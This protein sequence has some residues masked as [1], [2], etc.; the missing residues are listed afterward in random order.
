MQQGLHSSLCL[1]LRLARGYL[2]TLCSLH[3]IPYSILELTDASSES[4]ILSAAP[5]T[6][7]AWSHDHVSRHTASFSITAFSEDHQWHSA[8]PDLT[9][10][11]SPKQANGHF[12]RCRTKRSGSPTPRLVSWKKRGRDLATRLG[13]QRFLCPSGLFFFSHPSHCTGIPHLS[14]EIPLLSHF[15]CISDLNSCIY[16]FFLKP[17]TITQSRCSSTR[18]VSYIN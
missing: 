15:H 7:H 1:P 4:G 8:R 9:D 3:S 6:V 11:L 5:C 10:T 18:E 17:P 2:G 12:L 14:S 13:N 16:L